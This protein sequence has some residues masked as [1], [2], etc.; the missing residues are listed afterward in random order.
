MVC[1][2]GEEIT[3]EQL[4]DSQLSFALPKYSWDAEPPVKPNAD[5]TYAAPLPGVTKF[6]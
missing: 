3:W 5:G 2:T 4:M 6:V 1:Y